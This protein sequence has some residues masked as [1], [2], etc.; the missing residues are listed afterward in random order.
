[1]VLGDVTVRHR[2]SWV[3]DIEKDVHRF[4][5]SDQHRVLPD[6][7][8][9]RHVVAREYQ[10]ATGPVDVEG[11]GHRVVRVHLVGTA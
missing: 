6:Q 7:V 3:R 10:E 11:M 8:L 1:V 5:G 4:A 2:E 9:F